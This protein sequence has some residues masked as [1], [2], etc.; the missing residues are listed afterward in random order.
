[1]ALINRM[2]YS[3]EI[4]LDIRLFDELFFNKLI[5]IKKDINIKLF[6][7][8]LGV[9]KDNLSV[10]IY[11]RFGFGFDDLVMPRSKNHWKA[12]SKTVLQAISENKAGGAS[13]ASYF[14][15]A[16]GVYRTTDAGNG[17][18]NYTSKVMRHS[19]YGG[20]TNAS[21]WRVKDGGKWWLRDNAY[22]EPNG[23]Y[24]LNGLLG[25]G[26]LPNPYSLTDIDFND[27][28]SNYPTGNYYLVSTNAKQ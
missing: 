1:M 20:S 28:T 13:Y 24:G 12:M 18:G 5:Y 3:N 4:E 22:G 21:D 19:Y 11:N 10:Y 14:Q 23:D 2:N 27:L 9:D 17:D 16:Y 6:S 8:Q 15:T 7:E 26:G 25:G